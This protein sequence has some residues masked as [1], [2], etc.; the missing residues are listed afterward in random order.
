[1][2]ERTVPES[3]R[4][5]R[6]EAMLGLYFHA[7][8]G[9]PGFEVPPFFEPLLSFVEPISLDAAA[10][11]LGEIED[12]HAILRRRRAI[13]TLV[14][15]G[16]NTKPGFEQLVRRIHPAIEA[17]QIRQLLVPG[18]DLNTVYSMFGPPGCICQNVTRNVRRRPGYPLVVDTIVSAEVNRKFKSVCKSLDPQNWAHCS[19]YFANV[20]APLPVNGEYVGSGEADPHP[21]PPPGAP[22]TPWAD[23]CFEHFWMPWGNLGIAWFRNYLDITT[24]MQNA[25]VYEVRYVLKRAIG[26]RVA[27]HQQDGGL[28]VDSGAILIAE[29]PG[30]KSQVTMTK[31]VRFTDRTPLSTG[32]PGPLDFGEA[33]N[34]LSP[35]FLAAQ[36]EEA[37][38]DNICCT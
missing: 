29:I 30:G 22:G 36:L 14:E 32:P 9:R 4:I 38:C 31:S 24:S 18:L 28:D 26:S 6:A 25:Q 1:M 5:R 34:Y 2:D 19:D 15:T 3:A 35:F 37:V 33:L 16:F 20:Y 17:G 11:V 12:Q 7:H 27:I 8:R 23:I 21:G 10:G 13:A